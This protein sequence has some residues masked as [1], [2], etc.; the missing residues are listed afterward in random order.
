MVS[1]NV[2]LNPPSAFIATVSSVPPSCAG[3]DIFWINHLSDRFSLVIRTTYGRLP[4]CEINRL[5]KLQVP[6][7]NQED[8]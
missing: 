7:Q 2:S 8:G 3:L 1:L 4:P 5:P 6:I